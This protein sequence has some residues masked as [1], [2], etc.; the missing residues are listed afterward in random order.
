MKID[1][2]NYG[3]D[4]FSFRKRALIKSLSFFDFNYVTSI[5]GFIISGTEPAG[6]ARRIIFDIDGELYRFVNN[7]LDKYIW[8]GELDDV[9][10]YGNT[11]GE[12]LELPNL[13]AFLNKKVKLIIALDAPANADVFPKINVKVKA[14]SYNDTYT[15]IAYSPVFELVDN[16]R[17]ISVDEDKTTTNN[18]TA[19]TYAR[20][21][22]I[23]GDWS[24]WQYL[25]ETQG[26]IAT[27]IQFRTNYIVSTLD[28]TD[29]AQI[30]NIKLQY[31]NADK[32]STG[33]RTFVSKI[34]NYG[35]DLKKCY[36]LVKHSPLFESSIKA[37]VTMKPLTRRA[38]KVILGHTT[39]EQQTFTL[40]EKF[41]AQDTLHIEID[42]APVIDF[43]FDTEKSTIT[44]TA[45]V[46]RTVTAAFEYF[47]AENW[48]EMTLDYSNDNETRFIY[49]TDAA[50]LREVAVKFV[51][52]N[53]TG[54]DTVNLGVGTGKLQSFALA[55]T[56]EKISCNGAY[57]FENQVLSVVAKIGETITADYTWRGQLPTVKGY[58][59]GWAR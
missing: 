1:T 9:L 21:K 49:R 58:I 14:T 31:Q 6:T 30:H 19:T 26:Q 50:N 29:S 59:A 57:K 38:A 20:L 44:L 17:I 11:V 47:D 7:I 3:T 48:Y 13:N 45:E 4:S 2:I 52:E 43:D 5:T 25:A 39:G 16:A 8:R 22:K 15:K 37:F 32:S 41:I 40:S 12:L 36:L 18:A 33:S 10:I 54:K 35:G 55:H 23:T 56:P 27:Q 53:K 24:D 51:V 28:G 46:G 42:N 34:E